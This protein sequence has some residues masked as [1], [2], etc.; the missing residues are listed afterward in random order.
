MEGKDTAAFKESVKQ[1][2]FLLSVHPD[3]LPAEKTTS[4]LSRS[5][6]KSKTLVPRVQLFCLIIE[7]LLIEQTLH[8]SI[9]NS[10]FRHMLEVKYLEPFC[11]EVLIGKDVW[12]S[13]K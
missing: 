12:S 8:S 9:D 2:S 13:G 3:T 4:R 1:L 6:T 10:E 7:I 5:Y 11:T